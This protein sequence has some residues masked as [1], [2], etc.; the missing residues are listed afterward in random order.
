MAIALKRM[1]A[2]GDD[3]KGE[4]EWQV[5]RDTL[6]PFWPSPYGLRFAQCEN[7]ILIFSSNPIG[8]LGILILASTIPF[9]LPNSDVEQP[10]M[11]S[12]ERRAS[13]AQEGRSEFGRKKGVAGQEGLEPTTSGFGIRCSTNWSY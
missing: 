5:R 1:D 9:F 13:R 7:I 11:A 4:K 3:G 8:V 6:G 12:A 2:G 10:W